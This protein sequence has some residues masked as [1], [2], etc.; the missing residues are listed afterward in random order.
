MKITKDILENITILE[1]EN[2]FNDT[3]SKITY[4][5]EKSLY[6]R[7]K[8][9]DSLKKLFEND[10]LFSISGCDTELYI[11]TEKLTLTFKIT[12]IKTDKVIQINKYKTQAVLKV[13]KIKIVNIVKQLQI[14]LFEALDIDNYKVK[15]NRWEWYKQVYIKKDKNKK[16]KDLLS[17][18]EELKELFKIQY[19]EENILSKLNQNTRCLQFFSSVHQIDFF[20]ISELLKENNKELINECYNKIFEI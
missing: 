4:T 20:K 18:S 7:M 14:P 6:V 11:Y 10:N 3:V 13:G 12:T 2:L 9:I 16:L 1:L 8:M 17:S 19:S 5:S 15:I